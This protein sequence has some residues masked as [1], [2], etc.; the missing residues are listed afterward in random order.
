MGARGALVAIGL[1]GERVE[2][3]GRDVSAAIREPR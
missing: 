2:L 3:D 1:D